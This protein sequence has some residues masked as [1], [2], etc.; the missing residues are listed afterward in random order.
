MT[1]DQLKKKYAREIRVIEAIHER[2]EK[3]QKLRRRCSHLSDYIRR[4]VTLNK[5]L[6]KHGTNCYHISDGKHT[7]GTWGSKC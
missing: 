7:L 6:N 2:M 5:Q 4:I 1:L 3:P